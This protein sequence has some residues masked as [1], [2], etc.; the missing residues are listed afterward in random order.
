MTLGCIWQCWYCLLRRWWV[1]CLHTG[2]VVMANLEVM[3]RYVWVLM[4]YADTGD[5][6]ARSPCITPA[7]CQPI[8]RLHHFNLTNQRLRN[9]LMKMIVMMNSL[10]SPFKGGYSNTSTVNIFIKKVSSAWQDFSLKSMES[11]GRKVANLRS[12]INCANF[13]SVVLSQRCSGGN[14]EPGRVQ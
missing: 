10:L 5:A 7:Q 11:F 2:G 6:G 3:R 4:K 8:R 13:R 1:L 9:S 14:W 12:A